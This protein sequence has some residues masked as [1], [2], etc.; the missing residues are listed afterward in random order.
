MSHRDELQQKL[1]DTITRRDTRNVEC[2]RIEDSLKTRIEQLEQKLDDSTVK[3]GA[4]KS[5]RSTVGAL[6]K[7]RIEELTLLLAA[8]NKRIDEFRF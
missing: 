7:T 4:I 2:Q 5:T 1:D 6:I 8:K 3:D